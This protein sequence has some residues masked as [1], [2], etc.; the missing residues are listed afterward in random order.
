MRLVR[1]V[2]ERHRFLHWEVEFADVFADRGGFDLIL[3]NP[4][5]I[6]VEWDEGGVM[7][8]FEPLYGLRVYSAPELA[9]LRAGAM[10]RYEA[11]RSTY[12]TEYEATS[13]T[14]NFLN[15]SQNYPL[16]ARCQSNS[17]KYFVASA[18]H[19]F[20]NLEG[21]TAFVHDDGMYNDPNGGLLRAALY[22]RVR[23]YAQFE[24]ELTL[25][26]GLNDHG[27][28]R[29]ETCVYGPVA[30]T[31]QFTAIANLYSP[32][33][34]DVSVDSR[35]EAATVGSAVPGIKDSKG[36]WDVSGHPHRV[37]EINSEALALFASLYD[38]PG[39][40]PLQAC[41]P[42]LHTREFLSVLR[43]LDEARKKASVADVNERV[44]TTPSTCW[45]ETAAVE[46]G[47]IRRSSGF[48]GN[49]LEWI[50]SGPHFSIANP[51]FK[52]PRAVCAANSHY[53]PIDLRNIPADYLPRSNYVPACD[54]TVYRARTPQVPWGSQ[55]HVTDL[56]RLIFRRQLSQAGERTLITAVALRGSAHVNTVFS[57]A[58][59]TNELLIRM[60]TAYASLPFDF[61]MK[62][63]GRN[64]IYDSVLRN[65]ALPQ[66]V[67]AGACRILRLNCLTVG[68]SDLWM[69]CFSP[70][71]TSDRWTKSD[72]RLSND[73]Y[74][75]L[76][77]EWH[78][79]TPLRTDY[80][81]R[82]ALVEIDVLAAMELGLT[83]DELCTIYRI[84]FPVLRQNE[85]DTWY[86][87][88]GRIVFTS[89]KALPGVG[90]SRPEWEKIREM[91]SGTVSREIEDDTLPGGPRKRV[92]TY[93]APFDRCDREE[94]Y[95]TAWAE[96]EKRRT[97][98]KVVEA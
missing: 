76:T 2:A 32:Q 45:H 88:A 41:L 64:D 97:A 51:L 75:S 58:A 35:R 47:L 9:G 57:V 39:T 8:D 90:F 36:D 85:Q 48:S 70:V 5:W 40:P 72:P 79:S 74:Q 18:V 30:T 27:R 23:M 53:D 56:Y 54:A 10:E 19:L 21:V 59:D 95:K 16:L 38:P 55:P 89:S 24:N 83:L 37:L 86:D 82:Q 13:A 66:I 7:A 46:A 92:I 84:Q 68:Y 25:F 62:T 15:A 63:T 81:R 94:D 52:T 87:R 49:S 73:C 31:V 11:L 42:S 77:A 6:K 3:G 60:A 4:P 80:E 96:F 67:P 20:G 12:L 28:M 1:E 71:F 78:W 17:Y 43:K 33:T 26:H 34:I 91:T 61:Y 69:S 14:Q 44:F 22:P 98:A 50:M 65:L 29:F 93:E